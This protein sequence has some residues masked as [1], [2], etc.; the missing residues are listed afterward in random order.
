[1]LNPYPVDRYLFVRYPF[2]RYPFVLDWHRD[3]DRRGSLSSS[4]IV[5]GD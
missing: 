2:I 3:R 1:M 5:D 4:H